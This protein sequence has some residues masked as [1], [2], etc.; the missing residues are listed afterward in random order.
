MF[1]LPAGTAQNTISRDRYKN[2][3]ARQPV[4]NLCPSWVIRIL[5]NFTTE[6]AIWKENAQHYIFSDLRCCLLS[7]EIECTGCWK[8]PYCAVA[9]FCC[10]FLLHTTLSICIIICYLQQY[11][12]NMTSAGLCTMRAMRPHRAANFRGPPFLRKIDSAEFTVLCCNEL[13]LK[14]KIWNAVQCRE[15]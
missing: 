4:I 10:I 3:I 15:S 5:H 14:T 2:L 7:N 11:P 1:F 9:L 6:V 8:N 13:Q 12:C